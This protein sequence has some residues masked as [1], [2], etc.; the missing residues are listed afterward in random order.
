MKFFSP[1]FFIVI[2]TSPYVGNTPSLSLAWSL[3]MPLS[4]SLI[5]LHMLAILFL[6]P[7]Q[8]LPL[9]LNTASPLL[10]LPNHPLLLPEISVEIKILPKIL[11]F[12]KISVDIKKIQ[13]YSSSLKYQ[14]RSKLCPEYSSSLKYQ[15]I[16]YQMRPKILLSTISPDE[17]KCCS[18]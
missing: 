16:R 7:L 3:S 5:P 9:L 13:K 17:I 11:L 15:Q 12:P 14:S 10:L 8:P 4:L 1:V 6:Q 18:K 2:N